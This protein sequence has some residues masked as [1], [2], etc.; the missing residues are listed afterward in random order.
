MKFEWDPKKEVINIQKHGITF[1][2]ASYVFA[3]PYALNRYDDER[4]DEEDRWLL[5]GK[6]MNEVLLVVVHTFKDQDGIELIRIIS[7]RKA[8]GNEINEYQRRHP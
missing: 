2:Q 3:D 6:S 8:S 5:L 7:A 4:S 1:E